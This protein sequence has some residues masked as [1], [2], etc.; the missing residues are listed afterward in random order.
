LPCKPATV[1][2]NGLI[3]VVWFSPKNQQSFG[4]L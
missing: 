2:R 1:A 4:V 3:V